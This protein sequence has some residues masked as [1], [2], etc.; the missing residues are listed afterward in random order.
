VI[1][2]IVGVVISALWVVAVVIGMWA[3]RGMNQHG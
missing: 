1:W 3:F 2:L